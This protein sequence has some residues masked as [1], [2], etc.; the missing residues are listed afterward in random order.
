MRDQFTLKIAKD[1]ARAVALCECYEGKIE[2]GDISI[3]LAI[4]ELKKEIERIFP[5]EMFSREHLVP[6]GIREEK[7][8]IVRILGSFIWE[9]EEEMKKLVPQ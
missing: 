5:G 6:E 9:L 3:E 7:M 1:E 8:K 2:R 4:E